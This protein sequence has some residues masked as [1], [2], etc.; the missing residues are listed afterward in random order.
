[1]VRRN[2]FI[3]LV[4]GLVFFSVVWVAPPCGV[5][6]GGDSTAPLSLRIPQPKSPP[7]T[8]GLPHIVQPLSLLVYSE[9][10]DMD[11]EFHNTMTAINEII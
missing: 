10:A 1:M 5:P 2:S 3:C 7:P 9:Y 6:V 11:E 4:C 8:P